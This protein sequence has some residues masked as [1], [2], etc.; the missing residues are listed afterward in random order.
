MSF[1]I[2]VN[3]H[4]GSCS[5]HTCHYEMWIERVKDNV[6]IHEQ[7]DKIELSLHKIVGPEGCGKCC[8]NQEAEDHGLQI[9]DYRVTY[10]PDPVFKSA[11]KT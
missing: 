6:G 3:H 4:E 1:K 11:N 9:H 2:E 5:E 10:I 8:L 7:I